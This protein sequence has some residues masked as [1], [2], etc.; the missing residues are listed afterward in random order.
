MRV[1]KVA[2]KHSS[3]K[4]IQSFRLCSETISQIK[5]LADATGHSR[6]EIVEVAIDRMY[7]EE[8]RFGRFGI[9]DEKG[10]Y[11][12]NDGEVEDD[13]ILSQGDS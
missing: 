3:T 12:T 7:R 8:I 13:Q 4:P 1:S 6:G 9:A 5:E 11:T 10:Q 2:N